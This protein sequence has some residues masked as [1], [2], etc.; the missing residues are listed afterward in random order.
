MSEIKKVYVACDHA[1]LDM[2]NEVA[3]YIKE[4]GYEVSDEGTYTKESTDYPVYAKKVAQKVLGDENSLGLLFCG[5]GIGMSIAANK[6]KGIRATVLCDV[7]SAQLCRKHNNANIACFGARVIG[8][9]T[10]KITAKAFLEAEFEGG[11]HQ[12]RVDMINA[13]D[14]E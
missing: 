11:R 9:E 14:K 3:E 1:A 8:P 12:R 2:K 5:T 13:M 6:V 7:Y 10:A 4:L